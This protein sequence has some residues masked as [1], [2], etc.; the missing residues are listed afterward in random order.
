MMSFE[1]VAQFGFGHFYSFDKRFERFVL[2][3]IM[4][5]IIQRH[6][7]LISDRKQVFCELLYAI[8]L[9]IEYI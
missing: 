2:V 8:N 1:Y 7:Q 4:R 3:T 5:H 9:S 6:H